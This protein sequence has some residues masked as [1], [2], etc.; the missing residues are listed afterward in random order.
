MS[1]SAV[2]SGRKSNGSL[3]LAQAEIERL[4][5]ENEAAKAE[6]ERVK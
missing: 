1:R 3:S 6:A 2:R 5:A 4:K